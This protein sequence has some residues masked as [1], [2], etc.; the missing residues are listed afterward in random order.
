MPLLGL[1]LSPEAEAIRPT[2]MIRKPS[3]L[4]FLAALISRSSLIDLASLWYLGARSRLSGNPTGA[5]M[6]EVL[7]SN[8]SVP[9]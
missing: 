7:T 4:M 5:G 1:T 2:A 9:S 3:S 6:G 8:S